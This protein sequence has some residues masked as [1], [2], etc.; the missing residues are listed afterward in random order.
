[1]IVALLLGAGVAAG[2]C[3]ALGALAPAPPALGPALARLHA[4]PQAGTRLAPGVSPSLWRASKALGLHRLVSSAL[5]TDL[6]VAGRDVTWFASRALGLGLVGLAL[7]PILVLLGLLAGAAFPW[8]VAVVLSAGAVAVVLVLHMASVRREASR[9]R[10]GFGFA[11]SAYLDLVVVSMAAG[12]G[13]EGALTVAG[14]SGSGWAFDALRAALGSSRLRGITPWAALDELG[15][16]LGVSELRGLAASIELAGASGAKV[17]ASVAAR[18]RALRGRALTDA[19]SAAESAT[20]AMSLPV[21]LL[22]VGF[23]ILIGYP[24]VMQI[25]TQL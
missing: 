21:V 14:E 22:V 3:L 25:T 7:G 5:E 9:R 18:A 4:R 15:E 16:A 11:L 6:A 2:L 12:R 19:R 10:A 13:I 17:R 23:L 8:T 24:A 20:E 1:M